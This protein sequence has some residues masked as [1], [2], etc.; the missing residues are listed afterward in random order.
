MNASINDLLH[1]RRQFFGFIVKWGLIGTT[2][3]LFVSGG[4]LL[5]DLGGILS[6]MLRSSSPALWIG[7][8]CFD[9]WVT[10][11]GVTLA[12]AFWGLGDWSDP[13]A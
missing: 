7:F 2:I 9:I 10:V 4:F 5:A 6:L 11:T 8:F 1:S 12:V 13:S 3:S